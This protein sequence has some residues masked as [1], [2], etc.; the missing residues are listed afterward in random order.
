MT[1][2]GVQVRPKSAE[3]VEGVKREW[4]VGRGGGAQVRRGLWV[5]GG[6]DIRVDGSGLKMG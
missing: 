3:G 5:G 4:E 6:G 1:A 2:G